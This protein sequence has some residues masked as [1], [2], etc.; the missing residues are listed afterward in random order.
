M[1]RTSE[2]AVYKLISGQANNAGCRVGS[3][4]RSFAVSSELRIEEQKAVRK[5]L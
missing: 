4:E 1:D 2:L 3:V 5:M